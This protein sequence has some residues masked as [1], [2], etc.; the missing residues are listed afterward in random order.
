MDALVKN[1]AEYDA[2][3][4]AEQS[5]EEEEDAAALGG[6]RGRAVDR[7]LRRC[8][9]LLLYAFKRLCR[10]LGSSRQGARQGFSLAI[11]SLLAATQ[12][13]A[14]GEAVTAIEGV[15]EAVGKVRTAQR[16]T[17]LHSQSRTFHNVCTHD[18]DFV[19]LNIYALRCCPLAPHPAV[20]TLIP[21]CC[22]APSCEMP[23]WVASLD[24]LRSFA[25]AAPCPSTWRTAWLR[26]WCRRRRR[27]PSFGR[28]QVRVCCCCGN[29]TWPVMPA[30][31]CLQGSMPARQYACCRQSLSSHALPA[32][33][34]RC[35]AGAV[36][37]G[38]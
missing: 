24:M 10:G 23:C 20:L 38:G 13:I 18:H 32:R 36:P 8:S 29:A 16:G 4:G 35:A 26:G 19:L 21:F 12:C 15:L 2:E 27:N 34:R 14:P 11:T 5:E 30:S 7:A 9:P 1:Q 22:R 6:A 28:W 17:R 33:C 31:A 37:G 25:H 3:S